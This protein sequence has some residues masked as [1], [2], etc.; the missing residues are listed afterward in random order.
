MAIC[1]TSSIKEIDNLLQKAENSRK[2]FKNLDQ[3]DYAKKAS[4]LAEKSNN[5]QKIAESYCKIAEA[6]FFLE[7]QKQSLSYINKA[8][9]QPYTKTSKLLQAQLKE[10]KAF[11]Y[12]TLGMVSQFDRELPAI[13]HLLKGR[14]DETS[15]KLLQKTYLNIGASKPDS[16]LYY[17]K[18]CY[19]TLKKIPEKDVH[20]ELSDLYKYLGTYFLEK[21]SDSAL[22][23]FK[24]SLSVNQK[25]KD[26]VLFLDYTKFGDY[27]AAKK[28]YPE[29]IDYY[30]KAI[31]N[32]KEQS[33][34]PY[35]FVNNEL[36]QKISDLYGK[37]GDTKQQKEYKNKFS[38]LQKKLITKQAKNVDYALNVILKDKNDEFI[39][40]QNKNYLFILIGIII[41]IIILFITYRLLRKNIHQKEAVLN[42]ANTVLQ[43]KDE[44]ISQ[45][46]METTELQQKVNNAYEEVIKLAKDNDP[47]FYFRFQEVYPEFQ[48][49]LREI[50]PSLR[51]S[52]LILCAY[53]FLGFTIKDIADYTYKSVNTIRNRK[54]NLRKKFSIPTE[55][56]MEFWLNNL[57]KPK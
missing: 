29:A 19:E 37:S 9:Q 28:Q 52:E 38:E 15:L 34:A 27:Y 33:I 6:L 51:T 54:Q 13:T 47:S 49:K 12:Y 5:S 25:Y 18:L 53:T 22:F 4:V 16:A 35:H 57:I 7:L 1:Q 23:Y 3:L 8:S 44:L 46:N 21:K 43:Q 42:E 14:N 50:N 56:N 11:N 17:S 41:L 39:T 30:K 10:V 48:K 2:K 45:K 20:L 40:T 26:P 36:Y 55:Q 32:I 24:K 31:Q